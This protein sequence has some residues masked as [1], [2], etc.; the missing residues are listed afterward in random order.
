MAAG[1]T[2]ETRLAGIAIVTKARTDSGG[3]R[4]G[5]V[6]GSQELARSGDDHRSAEGALVGVSR[7]FGE[8]ASCPLGGQQT[9]LYVVV[10]AGWN[11]DVGHF[12]TSD[13]VCAGK[14]Q[15]AALRVTQCDGDVG[16]DT[17]RVD[18]CGVAVQSGGEIQGEQMGGSRT[19]P[20]GV[21]QDTQYVSEH[22]L[23]W[24]RPAGAQHGVDY[25]VG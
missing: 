4:S 14:T 10:Q 7:T 2:D 21:R 16:G 15:V 6:G 11:P 9:D 12:Q 22:A 3:G 18:L 20:T 1:A 8:R 24:S 13:I 17:C 25:E 5:K 23:D 19:A